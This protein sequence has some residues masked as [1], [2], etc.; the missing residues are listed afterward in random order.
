MMQKSYFTWCTV[1]RM[2]QA[3]PE[4]SRTEKTVGAR[5]S[6]ENRMRYIAEYEIS[7]P[8]MA[9]DAGQH[10]ALWLDSFE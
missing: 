6:K 3:N 5:L 2:H 8:A 7:T 10:L 4:S 1:Y 9:L